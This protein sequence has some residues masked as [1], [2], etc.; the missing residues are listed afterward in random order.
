MVERSKDNRA[1]EMDACVHSTGAAERLAR[2]R[3]S[4]FDDNEELTDGVCQ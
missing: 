1:V 4:R 3:L 2:P